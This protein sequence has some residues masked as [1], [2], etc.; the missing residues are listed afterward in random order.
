MKYSL[1]QTIAILARFVWNFTKLVFVEGFTLL[2]NSF[3]FLAQ[4]AYKISELTYNF[5]K[6]VLVG[7]LG[8][9]AL[10]LCVL[11]VIAIF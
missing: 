2:S 9:L 11:F 8:L 4:T 3:S 10:G 1:K 6:V 7:I 5:A